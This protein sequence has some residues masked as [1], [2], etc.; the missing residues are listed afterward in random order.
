MTAINLNEIIGIQGLAAVI[1]QI[2][3]HELHVGT[4]ILYTG[5]LGELVTSLEGRWCGIGLPGAMFLVADRR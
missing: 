1:N 3:R 5:D 2:R 4:P